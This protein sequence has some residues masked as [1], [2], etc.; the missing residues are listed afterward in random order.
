MGGE[1]TYCSTLVHDYVHRHLRFVGLSVLSAREHAF[2]ALFN[3]VVSGR[4]WWW[5]AAFSYH[6]V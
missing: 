3:T 1:I 2:A 6:C 5:C 4:W